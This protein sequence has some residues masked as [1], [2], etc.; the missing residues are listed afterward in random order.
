MQNVVPSGNKLD[1]ISAMEW[2]SLPSRLM[3]GEAEVRDAYP[4]R[5]LKRLSEFFI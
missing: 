3:K 1:S 4:G 2:W 5:E